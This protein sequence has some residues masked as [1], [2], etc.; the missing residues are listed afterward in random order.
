MM[1]IKRISLALAASVCSV[2]A[3]S[4]A[5]RLNNPIGPDG[6]Y[7]VRWD[8]ENNTWASSNSMEADETF[9]F[10]ID[11]SATEWES[12]LKSEGSTGTRGIATNFSTDQGQI[13][14]NG[15]RL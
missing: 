1:V 8:C 13:A 2:F 5:Q 15:D 14:R 6:C 7:I 3:V 9:T 4:A 12:W 10:A 11:I